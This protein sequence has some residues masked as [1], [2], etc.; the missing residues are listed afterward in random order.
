[1]DFRLSTRVK[2]AKQLTSNTAD[3]K[4]W[5]IR[6]KHNREMRDIARILTQD[7]GY[8]IATPKEMSDKYR[9]LFLFDPCAP[10]Q[11][12]RFEWA[13]QMNAIWRKIEFVPV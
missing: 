6:N 9:K 8:I 4:D 2:I 7:K 1:M 3:L 10:D 11:D 5:R 12:K 13:L